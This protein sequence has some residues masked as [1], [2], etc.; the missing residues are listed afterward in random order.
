VARPDDKVARQHLRSRE[1]ENEMGV[2]D[3]TRVVV[4]KQDGEGGAIFHEP[5]KPGTPL[6]IPGVIEGAYFWSTEGE[7][8]PPAYI[9]E[10]PDDFTFP[11]PGGT[12]FAVHEWAANSAGK[13]DIGAALDDDGME[14]DP[15]GDPEMHR[16]DTVDY[17]F[18]L[19]GKVDLELPGGAV[20]TLKAGDLLVM[21]GA[22]HAWKNRYDEPCRYIAVVIG[23]ARAKSK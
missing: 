19:S 15:S 2:I 6:N 12:R 4:V 14:T 11:G 21:G 22:A 9:G 10:V 3:E 8:D 7:L 13:F 20:T 16:T 18:I 23:A 5:P 1:G 17:E